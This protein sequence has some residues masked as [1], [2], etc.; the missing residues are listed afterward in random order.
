[1]KDYR[2]RLEDIMVGDPRE[3]W[4]NL[5]VLQREL[6]SL[7]DFLIEKNILLREV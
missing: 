3:R 5:E 7:S 6:W 2:Q 4:K 1:M